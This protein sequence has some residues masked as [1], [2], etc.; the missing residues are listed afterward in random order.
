MVAAPPPMPSS[1]QSAARR[2]IHAP[3]AVQPLRTSEPSTAVSNGPA[4]LMLA[5]PLTAAAMVFAS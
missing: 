5:A 1:A 2:P 3:A 4:K